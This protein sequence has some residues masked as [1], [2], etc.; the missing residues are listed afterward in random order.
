MRLALVATIVLALAGCGAGSGLPGRPTGPKPPAPSSA[1][2]APPTTPTPA[3]KPVR[4]TSPVD[5]FTVEFPTYH[6][7]P[8]KIVEQKQ[9]AYNGTSVN[10]YPSIL[11]T[12]LD[13]DGRPEPCG[14]CPEFV[15]YVGQETHP[16]NALEDVDHCTRAAVSLG[17]VE[18][19]KVGVELA[20][21]G[22]CFTVGGKKRHIL[23]TRH[24]STRYTVLTNRAK[25]EDAKKFLESFSF[26]A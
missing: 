16:K 20:V 2:S 6:G 17:N 19:K 7:D 1:Q 15:V 26:T 8:A 14:T 11:N 22:F 23:I 5:R 18:A 10:A 24:G 12:V 9:T 3:V 13:K 4:Y 25:D 21:Q